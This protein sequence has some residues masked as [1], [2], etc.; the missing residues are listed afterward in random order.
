MR[1]DYLSGVLIVCLTSPLAF[2]A[3][4]T[5]QPV[6]WAQL[7]E[8]VSSQKLTKRTA[9]VQLSSGAEVKATLRGVE[10]DALVVVANRQTDKRWKSTSGDEARIPRSEVTGLAILL[11]VAPVAG[12][13]IGHSADTPLPHFRIVP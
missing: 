12:Y 11:P 5:V 3:E 10:E 8:A 1:S 6:N 4:P 2:A 9:K 7:R 13:F